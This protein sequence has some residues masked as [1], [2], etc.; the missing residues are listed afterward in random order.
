LKNQETMDKVNWISKENNAI[1]FNNSSEM[2]TRPDYTTWS[3]DGKR[4]GINLN[5]YFVVLDNK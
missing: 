1:D 4:I 5:G 3:K 2:N